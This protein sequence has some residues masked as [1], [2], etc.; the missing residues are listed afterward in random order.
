MK[1]S[2]LRCFSTQSTWQRLK[3]RVQRPEQKGIYI[4]DCRSRCPCGLRH[5]FKR[6]DCWGWGFESHWEYSFTFIIFVVC[7]VGSRLSD[8]LIAHSEESYR[9]RA[10][11]CVCLI[12]CDLETSAMRWPRFDSG[13]CATESK[14]NFSLTHPRS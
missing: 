4:C 13:C 2:L 6:L 3:F 5:R 12:V 9:M 1:V 7:C 8:E 14:R 11:A 10:H